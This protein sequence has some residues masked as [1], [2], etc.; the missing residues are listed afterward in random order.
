ME[1]LKQL[2][3]SLSHLLPSVL[4]ITFV[5]MAIWLA[6]RLLL[7][8]KKGLTRDARF[9]RVIAMLLLIALGIAIIIL[10]LPVSDKM[11]TQLSQLFGLLLTAVIALSS[12]TFVA[13]AMAGLMLRAVRNFRPGDFIHIG[14]QFGRVT[15]R[16]F[17]H[18][19]IQTEE[20]NLTTLPNLF[21]ISQPITVV[22]ASGTIISAT[23]SLGYDNPH[24][25]IETLLIEAA[26]DAELTDPFVQITDLGDFSVT[27][28]IA[29]FLSDAKQI[30]TARSNLRAMMLD[31][32]HD[33]GIEIVSPTFMNQRRFESDA[34]SV[35]PEAYS[36]FDRIAAAQ[37]NIPEELIFDKAE[38]AEKLQQIEEIHVELIEEVALLECEVK[39]AGDDK[40]NQL[41]RRLERKQRR[42]EALEKVLEKL[43]QPAEDSPDKK[44]K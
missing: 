1:T 7:H 10:T 24:S 27:Y 33:G 29:G 31:T 20:R 15:D 38:R 19:E 25:V 40:I 22:R 34:R 26:L 28:R 39:D 5:V 3:S 23:V 30:L 9:P 8:R 36:R 44:R 4:A 18:T 17:F 13:N 35:P 14:T 43:R 42:A 16:G 41:Q 21:V 12:T 11:R 32:L 37:D 2:Y 6:N